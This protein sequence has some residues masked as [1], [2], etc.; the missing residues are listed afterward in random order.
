MG[1]TTYNGFTWEVLGS[2][3]VIIFFS[4]GF[5]LLGK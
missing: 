3:Q 4:N 5:N 2:I 1:V